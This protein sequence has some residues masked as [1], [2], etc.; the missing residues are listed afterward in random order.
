[1][2]KELGNEKKIYEKLMLTIIRKAGN[3]E[4]SLRLRLEV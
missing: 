3:D 2:A 1:M 4:S